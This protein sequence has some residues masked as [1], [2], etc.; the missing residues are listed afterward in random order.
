MSLMVILGVTSMPI[1]SFAQTPQANGMI[2]E[3]EKVIEE[4]RNPIIDVMPIVEKYLG[5]SVAEGQAID[6]LESQGFD[7]S[8]LT[9]HGEPR[10][11]A[12]RKVGPPSVSGF[13]YEVKIL[14]KSNEQLAQ[15]ILAQVIY[16]AL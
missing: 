14:L 16:R 3:I 9:E 5:P 6:F 11:L 15:V 7:V 10:I 12:H 8:R 4:N 13:H 2:A 1:L